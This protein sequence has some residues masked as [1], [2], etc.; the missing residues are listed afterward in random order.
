MENGFLVI[1]FAMPFYYNFHPYLTMHPDTSRLLDYDHTFSVSHK[2][3][4][5]LRR[6]ATI[7]RADMK[8]KDSTVIIQVPILNL[9]VGYVL[10]CMH[11]NEISQ[12]LLQS[13]I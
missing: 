2:Y 4:L 11:K 12:W 10:K 9:Y 5:S 6:F 1:L 8:S 13:R 7:R 3:L